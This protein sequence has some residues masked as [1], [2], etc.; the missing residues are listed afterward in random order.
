MIPYYNFGT[1]GTKTLV[2]LIKATILC[3]LMSTIAG[4]S[5]A[6]FSVDGFTASFSHLAFYVGA[7]RDIGFREKYAATLF[8]HH[9]II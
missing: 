1:M 6:G 8:E 2:L 4:L 7:I 5:A 3:S 9:L